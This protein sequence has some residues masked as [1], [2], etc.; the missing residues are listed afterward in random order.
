M[1]AAGPEGDADDKQP[2]E[3]VELSDSQEKKS[4]FSWGGKK[5]P[6][7]QGDEKSG[8][9]PQDQYYAAEVLCSV[10]K[11][12][13]MT[14]NMQDLGLAYQGTSS[15]QEV[16]NLAP[17]TPTSGV[18]CRTYRNAYNILAFTGVL[19]A[20]GRMVSR[21]PAGLNSCHAE[22]HEG[23]NYGL[24]AYQYKATKCPLQVEICPRRHR[25]MQTPA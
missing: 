18:P 1:E 3:P 21:K 7:W 20:I 4:W 13:W 11:L 16:E 15:A 17:P 25:W 2:D 6:R 24:A 9:A 10:V 22:V 8:D 23:R 12:N 5:K 19:S 14:V